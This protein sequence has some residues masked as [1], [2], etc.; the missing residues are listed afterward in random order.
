MFVFLRPIFYALAYTL[1][2]RIF[3]LGCFVMTDV[4]KTNLPIFRKNSA[5]KYDLYEQL[6]RYENQSG[7]VT[8]FWDYLVHL[9]R[10]TPITKDEIS[11]VSPVFSRLMMRSIL[12]TSVLFTRMPIEERGSAF[13][14]QLDGVISLYSGNLLIAQK[15]SLAG[16][17][18]AWFGKILDFAKNLGQNRNDT[19]TINFTESD[20]YG[21]VASIQTDLTSFKAGY[22]TE[23]KAWEK[24]AAENDLRFIISELQMSALGFTSAWYECF[25]ASNTFGNFLA[26]A[27][28]F[29][30]LLQLHDLP[31]GLNYDA[32][33]GDDQTVHFNALSD[34]ITLN[35]MQEACSPFSGA[36][37]D[38]VAARVDVI[39]LK[40]RDLTK[41]DLF[42]NLAAYIRDNN[43]NPSNLL[44]SKLDLGFSN[45]SSTLYETLK[46]TVTIT[47]K[48][49]HYISM[50]NIL[51]GQDPTFL[52]NSCLLLGAMLFKNTRAR[53]RWDSV[54]TFIKKY[55][56]LKSLI[57]FASLSRPKDSEKKE[58]NQALQFLFDP[59]VEYQNK[60]YE[61]KRDAL[62]LLK[63]LMDDTYDLLTTDCTNTYVAV[64]QQYK[65]LG[66]LPSTAFL[67]KDS[68]QQTLP[69]LGFLKLGK[70]QVGNRTTDSFNAN[71]DIP[72]FR[73]KVYVMVFHEP[74]IRVWSSSSNNILEENMHTVFQ[75]QSRQDI[76]QYLL[77]T[78]EALKKLTPTD[79]QKLN[80]LYSQKSKY[81][82]S[83]KDAER[84][85]DSL[86]RLI[87]EHYGNVFNLVLNVSDILEAAQNKSSGDNKA[88]IQ[89]TQKNLKSSLD[90]ATQQ[91]MDMYEQ[92]P[93]LLDNY[94]KALKVLQFYIG[95]RRALEELIERQK[96]E[97]QNLDSNSNETKLKDLN[98]TIYDLEL[99]ISDQYRQLVLFH[100]VLDKCNLLNRDPSKY[101]KATEMQLSGLRKAHRKSLGI[102]PAL[103][104]SE[105]L[106]LALAVAQVIFYLSAAFGI[107]YGVLKTI[108]Y[109]CKSNLDVLLADYKTALELAEKNCELAR[110]NPKDEYYKKL[111][112]SSTHIL[113][114][115]ENP[116][117]VAAER[118]SVAET[119]K[120]A[121]SKGIKIISYAI[122][123]AFILYT[124]GKIYKDIKAT[125]S[126]SSNE[127]YIETQASAFIT[128]ENVSK[129]G[130]EEFESSELLENPYKKKTHKK[131][132]KS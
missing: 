75:S 17:S 130:L 90:T 120:E 71:L 85:F 13:E 2:L 55:G 26:L 100:S 22:S 4:K 20:T 39:N 42:T 74:Y 69:I 46:N 118:E 116:I 73:D 60:K 62:A 97:K 92:Y 35:R 101:K 77:G 88:S 129:D 23:Q 58:Y 52:S 125:K 68:Q 80:V 117:R 36:T 124:F 34:L 72:F 24:A 66:I 8:I 61:F 93:K 121:I 132:K 86:P 44:G 104:A 70:N 83:L 14:S 19:K 63:Q 59:S 79:I 25:T 103:T 49:E 113:E 51:D 112:E 91:I 128:Q 114:D 65:D 64:E 78:P 48:K 110:K 115:L 16:T 96:G 50:L 123:S 67:S 131:R 56:F 33:I 30:N 106:S 31:N 12:N 38:V 37:N 1:T 127:R 43:L 84:I 95:N 45:G 29:A 11:Q 122:G 105:I 109:F 126:S 57:R 108:D 81:A 89:N 76:G 21:K 40:K 3:H 32:A 102:L 82:Y 119:P 41:D 53:F 7:Q 99:S 15:G 54:Q 28:F 47:Q 18:Y 87:K 9:G 98:R 10:I 111:C 6:F 94:E 27:T 107:I 5:C